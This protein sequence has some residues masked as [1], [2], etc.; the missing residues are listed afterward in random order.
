MNKTRPYQVYQ[1]FRDQAGLT[2]YKVSQ[3][4]GISTAVLAQWK[5][6]EYNLKLD[7]LQKLARVFSI[8]VQVFYDERIQYRFQEEA[9]A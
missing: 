8:P 5:R 2:D 6:G 3:Q 4:S 1:Y 9:Q 7:K